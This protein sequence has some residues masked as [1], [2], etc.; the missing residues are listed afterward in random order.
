[1]YKEYTPWYK[2][3]PEKRYLAVNFQIGIRKHR[4][5]YKTRLTVM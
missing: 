3:L 1:M 4:Y 5:W 2:E